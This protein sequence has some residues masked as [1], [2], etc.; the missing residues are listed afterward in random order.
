MI[1]AERRLTFSLAEFFPNL[2][3]PVVAA[4]DRAELDALI[5]AQTRHPPGVL[6]DNATKDY[7]LRHVFEIAPEAIEEPAQLLQVLLRR[8]IRTQRIPGPFEERLLDVLKQRGRFTDW[9]L[10]RIITCPDELLA[11]IQERWVPFLDRVADGLT[12][13]GTGV[14]PAPVLQFSGPTLLQFDDPDVRVYIDTLFL[15]GMLRP[16]P[17]P[18]ASALAGQ[19]VSVGI[20]VDPTADRARRLGSLIQ[21]LEQSIP[22][23]DARHPDWLSFAARWAQLTVL[24]HERS[25]S[26][27]PELSARYQ[28]L[29]THVDRAFLSWTQHRYGG[30]YNQPALPPVMVHHLSRMLARQLATSNESKAALVILD[31]LALDQWLILREVLAEQRP[32]LRFVDGA[33]FAFIPTVTAVSRQALFAGKLPLYFPGTIS[34]TNRE[35]TL[36]RQ[37]WAD[38]GLTPEQV[39][40][41]RGLGE[42]GSLGRVEETLLDRR[43]RVLG[44]VVNTVDEMAHG[45][46]LGTAGLHQQVRQ[47]VKGGFLVGLLDMLLDNGFALYLGSDHGN[48][49]AV[50]IGRS[51]EG[52]IADQRGERVRVYRDP[53]LRQ[54]V[55][56]RFPGS[57]AWPSLGLPEDF[58]PLMA[59]GRS[60]FI[61]VGE[62]IVGHG[63]ISVEELIVPFVRVERR[64]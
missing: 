17:Y 7:I 28:Q 23:N 63:G 22:A 26:D 42:E 47:W 55:E 35:E 15:N 33:V 29:Q 14:R 16:V 38:H 18:E 27:Q 40:Y 56:E 53:I 45:M 10:E 13:V 37:F 49:E 4:L 48:I 32:C 60:A 44:L 61:R 62:R 50:G 19:W 3:L 2:S 30:L 59:P 51:A 5:Q 21:T 31:G 25:L 6:G 46:K 54:R 57:I 24:S 12:G 58:A 8:Q 64:S 52:A 1:R 20:R 9:P 41:G 39:A 11:F 43:I 34:S 36:W